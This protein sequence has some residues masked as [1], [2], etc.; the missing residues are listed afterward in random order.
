MLR[1]L[2]NS[3]KSI[4]VSLKEPEFI[5]PYEGQDK[6]ISELENLKLGIDD[7][8]ILQSI[9]RDIRLIK[10]GQQGEKQVTYELKHSFL[11][12]YCLH[13]ININH[14]GLKAQFDFIIIS[15]KCI[16]VLETK[17][18]NGNI[19]IRNNGDF[20]RTIKS[21]SGKT[22]KK[23]G[24]YSPISQNDR[25]IEILEKFLKHHKMI[26]FMPIK[27]LVV[28]AN[29][30]SIL[31]Y[32]YAPKTIK[33]QVVKYDQLKNKLKDI[34]D[35]CNEV[36]VPVVTMKEIADFI[37]FNSEVKENSFLNK[38][39]K[40]KYDVLKKSDQV[41]N[42]VSKQK[43]E[44]E[45]LVNELKAYRL[46]KSREE[47]IKAYYIFNNAEMDKMIEAYPTTREELI[48]LRGFGPAK[49]DKYGED[50]LYIF[51]IDNV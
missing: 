43:K 35:T 11:P 40:Y 5:K 13:D 32:R 2:K 30:K 31:N 3:I 44:K 39:E 48:A 25:H 16:T 1:N 28:M 27:S 51:K 49:F 12:I 21:S 26:K 34:N 9:D 4:G 7:D 10:Y 14:E 8:R 42:H 29:P 50:I 22:I 19:E 37:T 6:A 17:T 41:V 36:N 33:S 38:Y 20:I 23:E 46:A 18:L 15:N 45:I 47:N 24:M